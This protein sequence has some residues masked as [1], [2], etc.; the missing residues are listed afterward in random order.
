MDTLKAVVVVS[1]EKYFLN[2]TNGKEIIGIP[3]SDDRPN[4]VKAS[5]N[6]LIRRLKQGLFTISMDDVQNDLFSQVASEYI[7]Q[8][9]RDLKEVF[10][11][12]KQYKLLDEDLI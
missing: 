2:I 6:K 7:K 11:E 1:N 10:G 5:F 9:N 12:L 8:L 4:E 3:L